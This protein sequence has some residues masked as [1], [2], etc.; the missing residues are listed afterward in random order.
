MFRHHLHLIIAALALIGAT[1]LAAPGAAA[2]GAGV[3][4]TATP[5]FNGTVKY[6]EW[7]P[8]QVRLENGGADVTGQVQVRVAGSGQRGTTYAQRVELP[9]GAKKEITLY[10]LPNTFSRRLDV[11][12]RAAGGASESQPLASAQV[13]VQPVPNVRLL[14]GA[15]SGGGRGLETIGAMESRGRRNNTIFLPLTLDT[16]PDR[17]EGLRSLDVLALSGVET[18]ALTPAQRIALEQWVMLG[19]T[20]VIGGGPTGARTLAGL[21]PSLQPVTI[22][23]DEQL[24]TVDVLAQRTNEPIR[25]NGPFPASLGM[26]VQG[27]TTLLAQGERPLIVT[28]GVGRGRLFWLALDPALSPFDA[29]AGA[30]PFWST[31][32]AESTR[33]PSDLP[34]DVS[35]RQQ[36]ADQVS[37]ALSNLPS[38]DLPSLRLLAPLLFVYIIVVGPLNYLV[39]RWQRRLELAWVTIPLLT[40]LFSAG[41]YAIGF[42]LRGGDVIVNQIAIIETLPRSESA[43]VRAFIG[44]FSPARQAYDLT[45]PGDVLVSTTNAQGNPFGPVNPE[46]TSREITIMQ[47]LPTEL[48]GLSVNQWSMQS[49]FAESV[50]P[51]AESAAITSDLRTEGEKIVGTIRNDSATLWRDVVVV[52]GQKFHRLGDIAPGQE[53]EVA[54]D[55]AAFDANQGGPPLGWLIF[56]DQFNN[57]GP[58]GPPRDVQIKQQILDALFSTPSQRAPVGGS[59]VQAPL[60]IAWTDQAP[61]PVELAQFRVSTVNTTLIY[62]QLPLRYGGTAVSLPAGLLSPELE[63]SDSRY[64]CYG[65]RPGGLTPDFD[66]MA[67]R[68]RLPTEVQPLTVEQLTLVITSDGGWFEPPTIELWDPAAEAWVEQESKTLKMGRNAI[69]EPARWFDDGTLRLRATNTNRDRGG[70]LYFDIAVKGQRNEN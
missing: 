41:A 1:L 2:Q 6:G 32:L 3:R 68:F 51:R 7:L 4:L 65:S 28:Q 34:P 46:S 19:G 44:I 8:I 55:L 27:A 25:V 30:S 57:P 58:S 63:E 17:A 21:P 37:Y 11:D 53:I 15:V 13:Q 59:A 52:Q 48:R 29:W 22:S 42:Q 60:L 23:G 45:V 47:G 61:L 26:P 35:L 40:L 10:V 49:F 12:F 16:L 62:S 5:F 50:V 38:L 67:M 31:L 54:I 24:A 66:E 14:V 43:S 18:G 9:R 69:T 39:L 70:C 33:Y 56:Q 36:V 64:I 20:L